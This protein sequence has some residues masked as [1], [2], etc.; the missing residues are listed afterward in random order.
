MKRARDKA[1]ELLDTG[2]LADCIDG[3]RR[4]WIQQAIW[5]RHICDH[6][7]TSKFKEL[8]KKNKKKWLTMKDGDVT[9]HVGDQ[10]VQ[11]SMRLD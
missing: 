3:G 11:K 4:N 9:H 2:D 8:F 1:L 10:S 5:K 6:W 7:E